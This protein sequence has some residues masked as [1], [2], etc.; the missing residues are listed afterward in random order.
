MSTTWPSEDQP[1]TRVHGAAGDGDPRPGRRRLGPAG[2]VGGVAALAAAA[3]AVGYFLPHPRAAA[4]RPAAPAAAALRPAGPHLVNG[5]LVGYPHTEVGARAAA[6]NYL[7]AYS[8]GR[9]FIPAERHRVIAAISDPAHMAA[10]TRTADG[11][12]G[13]V[14]ERFGLD[15]QGRPLDPGTTFVSRQVA[16]GVKTIAYSAP[17]AVVSVWGTGIVGLSGP[18]STKPVQEVWSTATVTLRWAAGDWRW[19]SFTRADG[20]V[21]V[22]GSAT[23]TDQT[24][25]GDA[26]AGFGGLS[27]AAAR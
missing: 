24:T 22:P 19:S 7:T 13:R 15:A 25:I 9:M 16:V 3:A 6:A 8:S 17:L 1:A 12:F 11:L 23:P 14:P 20:P 18:A 5:V 27:Y 4:T 21:P 10:L 2:V 26:I